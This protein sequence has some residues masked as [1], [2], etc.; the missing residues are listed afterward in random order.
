M[1]IKVSDDFKTTTAI[2]FKLLERNKD[3][4]YDFT[5]TNFLDPILNCIV[6]SKNLDTY[7]PYM[8]ESIIENLQIIYSTLKAQGIFPEIDMAL[9]DSCIYHLHTIEFL[10]PCNQKTLYFLKKI[11]NKKYVSSKLCL[12]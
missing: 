3:C 6:L 8:L 5:L 10:Q 1:I 7:A 12:D 4:I 2:I 11:H 9:F